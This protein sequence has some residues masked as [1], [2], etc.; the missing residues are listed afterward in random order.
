MILW[1]STSLYLNIPMKPLVYN[2]VG[3]YCID[4]LKCR[5]SSDHISFILTYTDSVIK[6][7]W[8]NILCM[9]QF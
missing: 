8:R 9:V 1:N 2:D 3:T 6:K 4:V 7:D 5:F